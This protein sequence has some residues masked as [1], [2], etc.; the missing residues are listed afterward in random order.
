[1]VVSTLEGSLGAKLRELPLDNQ[2]EVVVRATSSPLVA[3]VPMEQGFPIDGEVFAE[4]T[5][6]PVG[7][8]YADDWLELE[9]SDAE[10]AMS[11]V[12]E[13]RDVLRG[14]FPPEVI[15]AQPGQS[16][17]QAKVPARP[18]SQPGQR[19]PS[20][21]QRGYGLPGVGSSSQGKKIGTAERRIRRTWPHF[22][23]SAEPMATRR[24]S[25]ESLRTRALNWGALASGQ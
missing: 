10:R 21:P 17:S 1:M 24:R 22:W 15:N 8:R 13:V 25:P 4:L 16:P 20:C 3:L 5:P 7:A 19:T 18:K 23:P 6:N 9:M 14:L 11:L 2:Q 12:Q